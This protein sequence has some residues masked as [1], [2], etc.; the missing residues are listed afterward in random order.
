MSI[1]EG[2]GREKREAKQT[3]R[4]SRIENKLRVDGG[5]EVGDGLDGCRASRRALVMTLGVGCQ[6]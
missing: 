1:E 6:W 4:D 2:E 5:R 3:P